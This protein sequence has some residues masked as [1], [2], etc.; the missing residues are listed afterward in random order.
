MKPNRL[1]EAVVRTLESTPKSRRWFDKIDP[2]HAATL[3]ELKA[4]WEGGR[5]GTKRRRAARVI[6]AMLADEKI[7][8]I[9][10]QEVDEWLAGR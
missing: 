7:A 6:S 8:I 3:A 10:E 5:L 1:V 9:G 4:A 2:Q